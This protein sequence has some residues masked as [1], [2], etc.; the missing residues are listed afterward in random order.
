MGLKQ[1][2]ILFL[3]D[4]DLMSS[5][6]T[7]T[8]DRYKTRDQSKMVNIRLREKPSTLSLKTEVPIGT[9]I[10][11]IGGPLYDF[12]IKNKQPEI[13]FRLPFA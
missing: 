9:S 13:H 3:I 10:K 11:I 4:L 7:R 6:G 12:S 8:K 2:M 5:D 1:M